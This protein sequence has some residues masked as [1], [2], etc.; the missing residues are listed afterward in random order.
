MVKLYLYL[1]FTDEAFLKGV[2][3]PYKESPQ[4]FETCS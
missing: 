2:G 4:M 3:I 1:I